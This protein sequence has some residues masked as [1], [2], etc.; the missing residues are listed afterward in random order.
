MDKKIVLVVDDNDL[1]I[2]IESKIVKKL[3]YEVL[4]AKSGLE[5]LRVFNEKK[6]AA[7]LLDCKMPEMDGYEVAEKI[8]QIERVN[9]LEKTS[10][11]AVTGDDLEE[12]RKLCTDAGM[13]EFISKPVDVEILEKMLRK[14]L[15]KNSPSTSPVDIKTLM[16]SAD[17]DSCWAKELFDLFIADTQKRILEIEDVLR[18]G[19]DKEL[20]VRNFHTIKSSAASIGATSLAEIAKD[21]E[22]FSRTGR[23]DS[24]LSGMKDLVSE[25][26]R[27]VRF[28]IESGNKS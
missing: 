20:M 17:G 9:D 13:D 15:F 11:I 3:G 8:R 22:S 25:F 6:P 21:L 4:T 24:V 18:K 7:I 2:E 28:S 10:I 12:N 14:L 27:V 16:V 1:N 23:V 26:N 5:A 19:G